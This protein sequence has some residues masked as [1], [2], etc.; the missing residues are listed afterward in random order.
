MTKNQSSHSV[1]V[2]RMRWTV[3]TYS[4]VQVDGVFTGNNVL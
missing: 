2:F 3:G 1:G 4:L